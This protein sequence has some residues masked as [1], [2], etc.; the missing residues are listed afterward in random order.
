[1]GGRFRTDLPRAPSRPSF[2]ARVRVQMHDAV[3][4][5]EAKVRAAKRPLLL[6]VK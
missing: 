6:V 1:M 3:M 5:L 2:A 4:G